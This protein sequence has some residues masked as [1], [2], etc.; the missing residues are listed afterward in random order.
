MFNF[1]KNLFKKPT[2]KAV[3][4]KMEP[5]AFEADAVTAGTPEVK[6]D[7]ELL[8]EKVKGLRSKGMS[9]KA[10]AKELKISVPTA[11]KYSKL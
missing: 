9:F 7:K 4:Y 5:E 11:T 8:I 10:I 1:I 3:P 2:V 6:T